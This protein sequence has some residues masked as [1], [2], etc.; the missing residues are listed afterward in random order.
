MARIIGRKDCPWCGFQSAHVKQNEGKL[1][2]HHC[3]E[4][5][6]MT[7]ARNGEQARHICR[8]MR[9]EPDYQAQA[10][11]AQDLA[12]QPQAQAK[13]SPP[14]PPH[15]DDPIIVP[16]VIVKSGVKVAPAKTTPPPVRPGGNG[17]WSQL[18]KGDA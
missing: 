18:V 2:Y 11:A 9:P 15:T 14:V 8:N 12:T 6:T 13:A 5:G 17:L 1:P 7:P 10:Q 3:P 4:C 16:G